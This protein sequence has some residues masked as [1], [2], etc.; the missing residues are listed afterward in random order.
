MATIRPMTIADYA[1]VRALWEAC[2]GVSLNASDDEPVIARYLQRNAGMSPV[3]IVDGAI[4]GA[5]LC[6][7]DGR[8]GYINHLAVAAD[9]RRRGIATALLAHAFEAL[10]REDILRCHILVFHA[11]RSGQDFWRRHGW[12]SRDELLTMQ[13]LVR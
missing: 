1:A 9:H 5:L 11:N 7:H 2:E 13:K 10:A 12:T 3:G 6:G 4:V 8:R